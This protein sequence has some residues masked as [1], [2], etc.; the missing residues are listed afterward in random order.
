MTPMQMMALGLLDVIE[1]LLLAA[2]ARQAVLNH[3]E[4]EGDDYGD[5]I[6]KAGI[7]SEGKVHEVVEQL[8]NGVRSTPEPHGL[9]QDVDSVVRRIL[10]QVP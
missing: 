5:L 4:L 7:L 9:P 2:E 6:E 1:E 3:L 10:K 8:R